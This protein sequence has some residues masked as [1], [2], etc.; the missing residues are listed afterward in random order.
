MIKSKLYHEYLE[1]PIDIICPSKTVDICSMLPELIP[2][3][4]TYVDRFVSIWRGK[5]YL[6][7]GIWILDR[8]GFLKVYKDLPDNVKKKC[9][10]SFIDGNIE[11]PY[12]QI[13]GIV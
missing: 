8:P 5:E 3:L 9:W 10:I 4:D 12:L 13:K 2:F 11:Q 7:T 6:G 1:N